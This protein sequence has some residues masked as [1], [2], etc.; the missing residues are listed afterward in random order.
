MTSE[1]QWS[2]VGGTLIF[3]SNLIDIYKK[4]FNKC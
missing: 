1:K 3:E 4:C 2:V